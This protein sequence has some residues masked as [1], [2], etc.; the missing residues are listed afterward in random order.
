MQIRS[1]YVMEINCYA[2]F[3]LNFSESKASKDYS[4]LPSTVPRNW[5]TTHMTLS[6]SSDHLDLYLAHAFDALEAL[7]HLIQLAFRLWHDDVG[8]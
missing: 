8:D 7:F 4:A 2:I 3:K 1:H 6:D 5:D